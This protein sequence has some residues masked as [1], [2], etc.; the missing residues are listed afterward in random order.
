TSGAE[1]NSAGIQS[2]D[3]HG[4]TQNVYIAIALWEAVGECFPFIAAA[5]A[6]VNAQLAIERKVLG[7]ALDGDDVDGFG[8]V[9]MDIN[10][11]T[12]IGGKIAADFMPQIARI[13]A[14]H[15]VPMFLHIEHIGMGRMNGDVVHAMPDFGGGIG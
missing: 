15:D 9:R 5:A 1:I 10:R 2:I 11:K 4:I 14:A 3:G 8:L 6:A 12:K 7:I 13:I